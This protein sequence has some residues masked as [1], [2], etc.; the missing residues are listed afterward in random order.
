MALKIIDE[1][2]RLVQGEIDPA[3]MV[4]GSYCDYAATV[5]AFTEAKS[6]TLIW[7]DG[8]PFNPAGKLNRWHADDERQ[9]VQVLL[10]ISQGA[11]DVWDAIKAGEYAG[12][13]MVLTNVTHTRTEQ[14]TVMTNF[15]LRALTLLQ[16]TETIGERRASS[17][18]AGE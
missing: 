9:R 5:H 7:R 6:P 2:K 11:P 17:D 1:A 16:P 4:R 15:S 3:R 18:G 14:G 12:V 8:T 10:Y 13:D